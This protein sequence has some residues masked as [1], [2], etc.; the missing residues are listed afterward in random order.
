[1][2][3]S[4]VSTFP[5]S[6]RVSTSEV[7][8]FPCSIRVSTSEVSTG[9][10]VHLGV[11]LIVYY[12]IIISFTSVL[13]SIRW[14]LSPTRWKVASLRLLRFAQEPRPA[15]STK[16]ARAARPRFPS[17]SVCTDRL[18][19]G[20]QPSC[21]RLKKPPALFPSP[22]QLGLALQ[23]SCNGA[24]HF[25]D[26][27]DHSMKSSSTTSCD[28]QNAARSPLQRPVDGGYDDSHQSSNCPTAR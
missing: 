12:R 3:T 9:K 2:S 16:E 14:T 5:C 7:S 21:R 13:L 23:E 17:A 28:H 22:S 10:S 4:E 18:F 26:E 20:F 8:T 25:L 1:M 15:R 11:H 27:F 6:I 19:G 24:S